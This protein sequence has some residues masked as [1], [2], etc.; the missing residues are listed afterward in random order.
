MNKESDYW[1]KTWL[2]NFDLQDHEALV[3]D[4][5]EIGT[6]SGLLLARKAVEAIE[7]HDVDFVSAT[8]RIP[9]FLYYAPALVHT[10]F[11][12]S[13]P[14]PFSG[15]CGEVPSSVDTHHNIASYCEL[16]LMLDSSVKNISCAL[17][18]LG[19]ADNTLMIVLSDNGGSKVTPGSTYPLR[20]AKGV[21]A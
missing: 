15:G 13:N 20:G 9:L 14:A 5:G 3:T 11:P 12:D 1:N 2:G 19:W 8:C 7:A 4:P 16:V 18:R 10:P 6:H 17:Q 21:C